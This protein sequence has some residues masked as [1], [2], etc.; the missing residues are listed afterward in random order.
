MGLERLL[1]DRAATEQRRLRQ[2]CSLLEKHVP[3]VD[4]LGLRQPRQVDSKPRG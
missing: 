4:C 1:L 2:F 3:G